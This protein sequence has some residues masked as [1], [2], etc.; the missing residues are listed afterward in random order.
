[1][2]RHCLLVQL[3][4]P[5]QLSVHF[6][7]SRKFDCRNPAIP[8]PTDQT[9]AVV[10]TRLIFFLQA[11]CNKS[12]RFPLIATNLFDSVSLFRYVGCDIS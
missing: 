3:L 8:P 2:V 5:N 6:H 12:S 4:C 9:A 1:M 7:D 10:P 11:A